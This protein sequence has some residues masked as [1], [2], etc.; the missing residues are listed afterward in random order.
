MNF[1]MHGLFYHSLS[2]YNS[3]VFQCYIDKCESK[4]ILVIC[5]KIVIYDGGDADESKV[6]AR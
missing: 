2:L 4:K 1:F 6:L 3:V 5:A